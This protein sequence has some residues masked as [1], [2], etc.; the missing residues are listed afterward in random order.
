MPKGNPHPTPLGDKRSPGRPKGARNIAAREIKA[1]AIEML[2]RPEYQ[3]SLAE[4]LDAGDAPHM[5]TL[6]H[7]YGYGKPIERVEHSGDE[8]NPLRIVHEFVTVK[9]KSEEQAN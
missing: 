3:A 2:S 5:E 4:R 7:H 1:S 8:K 9:P 6:L